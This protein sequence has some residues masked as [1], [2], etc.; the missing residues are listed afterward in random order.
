MDLIGQ[1]L[2]KDGSE[3]VFN[4]DERDVILYNLGIGAK[5]TD[6]KYVLYVVILGLKN[7]SIS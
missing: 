6:L 3:S 2:E 1:V 7:R 4:Y 5:H